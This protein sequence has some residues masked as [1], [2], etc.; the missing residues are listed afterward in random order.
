MVFLILET[1][2]NAPPEPE[3]VV[4]PPPPPPP[5]KPILK[6]DYNPSVKGWGG[7]QQNSYPQENGMVSNT[8]SLPYQQHPGYYTEPYGSHSPGHHYQPQSHA[9]LPG[10]D[11]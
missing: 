5:P 4:Q 11:L 8:N 1:Q 2:R 9:M 3:P 7:L 6:R 10:C